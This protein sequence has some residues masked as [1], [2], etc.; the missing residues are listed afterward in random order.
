MR[1]AM[2]FAG[3]LV[4]A[5]AVMAQMADKMTTTPA[6]AK[7]ISAPGAFAAMQAPSQATGRSISI[8]RDRGGHFRIEA[9]VDG[10]RIDF[11]VDTG[12]SLIALNEKSAAN[13]GVRPSRGAYTAVVAT[14]NGSI[15]AARTRLPIVEIGGL[16]VR[17]VEAFVLPDE[18]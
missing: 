14:A 8:E 6:Q 2:I 4:G 13:I 16:I 7:A 12:A 17:D 3:L 15:K 18:A 9:R 11:M 10:Q 5:G 1:N